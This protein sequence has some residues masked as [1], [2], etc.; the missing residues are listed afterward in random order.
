MLSLG[1]DA[2]GMAAYLRA[3]GGHHRVRT[4]VRTLTI[5]HDPYRD[6]SDRFI[7]GQVDHDTTADVWT[8]GS[9]TLYDPARE[10]G[11]AGAS[12]DAISTAP[13]QLMRVFV[14]VLPPGAGPDGWV[15]VPVI[16][17]SMVRGE[18]KGDTVEVELQSKSTLV[19]TRDWSR[20]VSNSPKM[21]FSMIWVRRWS[22][23][24]P[25]RW[26]IASDK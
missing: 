14:G 12:V 24:P 3:V 8:S 16:T 25:S 20:A 5:N 6:F 13:G 18:Q 26:L 2:D 4:L 19:S 7:G 22:A 1:L 15:D 9:V 17:A 21:S 23:S 11:L 10:T